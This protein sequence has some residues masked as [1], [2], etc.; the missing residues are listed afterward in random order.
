MA[1]RVLVVQAREALAYGTCRALHAAGLETTLA[2]DGDTAVRLAVTDPPEAVVCDL[3]EPVLDGWYVL[4]ALGA[5]P[6]RP[7]IVAY[8]RLGDADRAAVLGADACVHDRNRIAAAVARVT[9]PGA[10][11]ISR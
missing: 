5:R 9:G 1:P 2:L 10:F 7:R 3:T 6:V 11:Q 4:A 8:G